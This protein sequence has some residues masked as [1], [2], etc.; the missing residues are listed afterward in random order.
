M[1]A[2][3]RRNPAWLAAI[4][5]ALRAVAV[6][7][8]TAAGAEHPLYWEDEAGYLA[9]AQVLAGVGSIPELSG[10]PYYIGWSFL[11]VPL[12]WILQDGQ[13]VYLGGVVLSAACGIATGIPL[14]LIARRWGLSLPLAVVAAG[15]IVIA[16]GKS[17]YSGFAMSESF[18][19]LCVVLALW[20]ALRFA[21]RVTVGRAATFAALVSLTF[22]T[23]GR[24][25]PLLIAAC[26]WFVWSLRRHLVVGIVGLAVAGSVSGSGF[27]LYRHVAGLIYGSAGARESNG[28]SRL[29]NPDVLATL[30]SSIGLG[31]SHGVRLCDALP[32]HA[33]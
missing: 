8:L 5:G 20:A 1:V 12:W 33:A 11:L 28:L 19:T 21:E 3:M 15:V 16:P 25:V 9:N 30:L 23:H 17:L 14:A 10:R 6:N 18:L 2:W 22:L 4:G 32:L 29:F 24:A 26:L 31:R 27:L 7:V 13:A